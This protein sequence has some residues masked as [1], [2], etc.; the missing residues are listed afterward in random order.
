MKANGF[1]QKLAI[2]CLC[3]LPLAA[4]TAATT[5]SNLDRTFTV[6]PGGTFLLDADRG[7]VEIKTSGDG[8]VVVEVKRS[9]V[10]A[11][12]AK[13]Q[14]IFAA[15]EVKFSQEGDKVIVQETVREKLRSLLNRGANDLQVKF[16]VSVPARF[17]LDLRT[18]AGSITSADIEGHIKARTAGGSLKF[19][20]V[21]GPFEGTTAAGSIT[22]RNVMGTVRAKTSGGSIKVGQSDAEAE[23][24]T[25]AGSITIG[26]ANAG[27]K[28]H[29]SGGSIEAGQ[30]A[31]PARLETSAGSIRVRS[32]ADAVQAHTSGGSIEIDEAKAAVQARTSAGSITL[33]FS[34]QPK[35]ASELSTS[36]GTVT[37]KVADGLAFNVE[38]R[39]SGGHV[40]TELPITSTVVG[41]HKPQALK[42][43]LNGGGPD[44]T[45]KTS[46]GNVRILKR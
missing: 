15:H 37:V 39:A 34:A 7:S 3:A 33:G 42:G 36:G 31:G 6:K 14:E 25:A 16:L 1:F 40:S 10:R 19:G 24:D 17:N 27:L 20:D 23:L 2:V 41:E 26:S 28:A 32:S 46:A 45:L 22:V 29:T 4:A 12:E 13:A 18:S 8:Q 38:A 5:E 30:L 21:K 35:E 44:L 9:V 43:T 11:S